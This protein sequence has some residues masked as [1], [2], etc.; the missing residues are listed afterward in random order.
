MIRF[1]RGIH[2]YAPYPPRTL[3]ASLGRELEKYDQVC[4]AIELQLVSDS[5]LPPSHP[6]EHRH[7]S[8][9]PFQF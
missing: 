6:L 5:L 3:T 8:C 2:K 7:I 1:G 4:D 9:V